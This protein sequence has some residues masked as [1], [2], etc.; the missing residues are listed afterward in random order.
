MN[1]NACDVLVIGE[2][3]S[4]I[5][6]AAA[7]AGE[8]LRVK[9]VTKGPGRFV[10]GTACVDF[11]GLGA[12][13]LGPLAND[14]KKLEEA[15]A[16]FLQLTAAA[17]C[18]YKGGS[19]DRRLVPTILGTFQE[20]SLAPRPLWYGDPRGIQ[21][22][23][24]AGIANLPGFDANFVA[25]RLHF[26]CRQLGLETSYQSV[27]VALPGNPQHAMTA[28]EVATRIDR[29]PAYRNEFLAVLKHAAAD[30]EQLIIP[31]VLGV[32]SHDCDIK[33]FEKDVGCTVCELATL[34]PS[35]PGMRIL[36][37][38]ERRLSLLGVDVC[39]GFSVQKLS[40]EGDCWVAALETPGRPRVIRGNRVVLACGRFSQLLETISP[41]LVSPLTINEQFE[42]VDANGSVIA[43]NLTACGSLLGK[44]EAR[45]SNAI[46]ILT[47]HQAGVL[48]SKQEV[49]YAG[50]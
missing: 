14:A 6:A 9:L 39:T 4:G 25:E 15:T 12:N 10:L 34:P 31:G 5:T 48:A 16:F 36:Q 2:G 27:V 17:G 24:V 44:F 47:G 43:S 41:A 40:I 50:R 8:G 49:H 42:P 28:I 7:A 19:R 26:Q 13:E 35:V 45:H 46:D 18:A 29:D 22:A 1:A 23:V 11:D 21:N 20:A 37:R 30:A 33:G 32:N 3:L 38:L